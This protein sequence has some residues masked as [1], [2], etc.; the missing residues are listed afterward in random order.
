[1]KREMIRHDRALSEERA[2]ELLDEATFATLA[3]V[4]EDGEP[5]SVPKSY[6][7]IGNKLYIHGSKKLGHTKAALQHEKRASLSVVLNNVVDPAHFTTSFESVIAFGEMEIVTDVDEAKA[8]LMALIEKYS[9]DFL[10][11]GRAYIERAQKA[12]EVYVFTIERLTAK[13]HD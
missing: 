1:M 8:G 4:D 3:L 5:Y 11:E 9:P 10:E 2:Y 7:R 12:T 6:A 13:K